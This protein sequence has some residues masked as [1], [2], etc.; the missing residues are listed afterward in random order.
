MVTWAEG[1]LF[2]AVSGAF[3]LVVCNPPYLTDA[4]MLR[5]QPEVAREPSLALY[6][7]AD[8]LVFYR[9]ITQELPERLNPGGFMLFEVGMGQAGAVAGMLE[10]LGLVQIF[11]DLSGAER[12]VALER[13]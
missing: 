11:I 8:G 4:D 13:V 6:G 9:R 3:E 1:D 7:G 2:G 10:P 5:L 12:V